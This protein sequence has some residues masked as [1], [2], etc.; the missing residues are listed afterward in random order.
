MRAKSLGL[1]G[2]FWAGKLATLL[3]E[4]KVKVKN[5]NKQGLAKSRMGSVN[6]AP[7]LRLAEG[8]GWLRGLGSFCFCF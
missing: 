8:G 3:L 6:L 2:V 1:L 7:C 5:Q 4:S